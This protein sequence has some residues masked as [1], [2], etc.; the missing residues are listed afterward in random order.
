M[1]KKRFVCANCGYVFDKDISLG[2]LNISC[3]KYGSNACDSY[4]PIKKEWNK[5]KFKEIKTT[6][7][8]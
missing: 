8:R 2:E 4:T 3:P 7:G 5:I 1:N 6:G